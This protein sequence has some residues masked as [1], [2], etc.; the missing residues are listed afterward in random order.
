MLLLLLWLG[1][2]NETESVEALMSL[3]VAQLESQP[4][5][6]VTNLPT[7]LTANGILGVMQFWQNYI[8]NQTLTI[9][10]DPTEAPVFIF[11]NSFI[12]N[13]FTLSVSFTCSCCKYCCIRKANER[14]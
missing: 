7:S 4:D 13:C 12:E 6:V 8:L 2:P 5:Q 11:T 1:K 10:A 9:P 14:R 3:N